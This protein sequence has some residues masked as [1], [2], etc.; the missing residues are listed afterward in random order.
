[1]PSS[2]LTPGRLNFFQFKDF[3]FLA[4]FAH[5][6]HGLK[7][8]C[9]FVSKL[10]YPKKVGVIS[11]TGDRRD[12]DIRELGAIS[13]AHFDE[14]II[15]CDKNLRGRTAEE[16]IGLLEE[17]IREVNPSIPTMVIPNEDQ[18]LEW[19]Y[20]NHSP[21]ALYTVMCDVVAG[22]LD[23]IRELREREMANAALSAPGR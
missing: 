2:H 9:D 16:I 11:G 22:A 23:K 21:G 19:I 1:V 15:R 6:P 5:N 3:T 10:D 18:A 4:D 12:E 13:A 7:L 17:G 8:L 20:A 14:I